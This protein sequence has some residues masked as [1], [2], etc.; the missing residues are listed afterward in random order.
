ME[1]RVKHKTK[2]KIKQKTGKEKQTKKKKTKKVQLSTDRNGDLLS[3]S[4]VKHQGLSGGPEE[5]C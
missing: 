3:A 4:K 5:E 1:K 2:Q